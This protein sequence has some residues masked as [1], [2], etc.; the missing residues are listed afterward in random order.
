MILHNNNL[1]GN[2]EKM[3]CL[4]NALKY[5]PSDM[6]HLRLDISWNYLGENEIKKFIDD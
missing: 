6:Q 3:K 1:G 5:L 2:L 4:G